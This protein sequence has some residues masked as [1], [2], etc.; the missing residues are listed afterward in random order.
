VGFNALSFTTAVWQVAVCYALFMSSATMLLGPL[1]ATTLI[2]RWFSSRRGVA[3]GIAAVGPPW[4]GSLF[5]PLLQAM[6]SG[7]GWR[8]AVPAL[9]GAHPGADRA[10]RLVP[11]G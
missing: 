1:T 6:M 11:R 5:P 2:A 9:G 3:L 7:F 4:A 10:T 8:V